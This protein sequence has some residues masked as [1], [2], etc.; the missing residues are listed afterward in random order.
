LVV[1]TSNRGLCGGYN[2]GVLRQAVP[3]IKAPKSAGE[4]LELEIVGKRGVNFL[5]FQGFPAAKTFTDFGDE[6]RFENVD[7]LAERYI[8]AYARKTL[9]RLDVAYMRFDSASR[10]TPVLETLLPLGKLAAETR[11][12]TGPRIEYEFLPSAAEILQEIVPAAFKAKLFKCFLDAAVSEQIFR[13][14]AM[15]AATENADDMIRNL[16]QKY[17]RAR[18][19]QIT[20]ELAEIIGGVA[21]LE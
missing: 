9:D 3:R 16:R 10:Q 1:L 4:H 12:E 11:P 18:Q 14:V 6:P 13:M 21:A 17:N 20:S 5:K 8:D 2:S 19:T 15:K 7:A